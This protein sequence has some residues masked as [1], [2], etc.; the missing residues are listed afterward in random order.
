MMSIQY[1]TPAR[2]HLDLDENLPKCEG[3]PRRDFRLGGS[4]WCVCED[5]CPIR[6]RACLIFYGPGQARRVFAYPANWQTMTDVQLAA[7]SWLR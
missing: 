7:L 2:P 6:R 4:L 3:K 1:P 5:R